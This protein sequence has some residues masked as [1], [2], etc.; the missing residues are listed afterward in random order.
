MSKVAFCQGDLC[1][2]AAFKGAYFKQAFKKMAHCC[3]LAIC[4]EKGDF[5]I[6]CFKQNR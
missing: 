3:N 4:L 1:H 2:S 5:E 6:A